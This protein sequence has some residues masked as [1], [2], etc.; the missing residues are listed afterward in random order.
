MSHSPEAFLHEFRQS[1]IPDRLTL[2]NVTWVEGHAAVQLLA[3]HAIAATQKVTSFV[4]AQARRILDKYAFAAAGGWVAYGCTL[5]GLPATVGYFKPLTPRQSTEFKTFG[6]ILKPKA[7]KYEMPQGLEALPLLPWV[8][9][10]TAQEIYSRY[11]V[12]PL[13]GERFWAVVQRCNLPVAITEGLKKAL[14]LIAHGMPAISLR[15]ICNWHRKGETALHSV[16]AHFATKARTL[17]IVFDQ[18]EKLSTQKMVRTQ[19][20]KLGAALESSKARVS[21]CTWDGEQ[22]KG[23]DDAVFVLGSQ[24]QT[25]LDAVFEQALDLKTYKRDAWTTKAL[26]MLK[27]LNGLAYPIERTTEGEYLPELPPVQLGRI[28]ILAAS[29]NSG[30]TTRIGADWVKR[31]ISSGWNCLVLTPINNLGQQAAHDWRLPHIHSYGTRPDEQNA[32]WADAS[33]SHGIVMCPDSLHRLPD[34][35]WSRPTLLIL[36]EANQVVDHLCQGDTLGSRYSLIL[37]KFTAAARHAI[38]TGAIVLSE[39]GLP[40]R[41]VDF[42]KAVSSASE[43]RVFKHQ[44]QGIPWSCQV[45]SGQA[46]GYR[47]ALPAGSPARRPAAVHHQL[48]S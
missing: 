6:E 18:D 12:T 31:A 28:H 9:E 33:Y 13:A 26:E 16:L 8:D 30:K 3:E 27:R 17:Y 38:Q 29:M 37:E 4:S 46:S 40:D 19:I 20:L 35:F 48:A 24:A 23:I 44:K 21:V 11:S 2:A 39:D 45:F 5:D 43:A 34:W 7:V 10:Q 25:W 15:G 22:G 42:V 32:L 47:A 14:C 41:A 36:D 1:A